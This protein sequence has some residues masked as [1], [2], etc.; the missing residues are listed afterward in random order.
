MN[1]KMQK[2]IAWHP[3]GIQG[4][5]WMC[6]VTAVSNQNQRL[7]QLVKELVTPPTMFLTIDQSESCGYRRKARVINF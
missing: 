7:S 4:Q 6:G 5:T 2:C 3:L 1:R